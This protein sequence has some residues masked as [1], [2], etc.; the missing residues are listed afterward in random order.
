MQFSEDHQLI[1]DVVNN[2]QPVKHKRLTFITGKL[3]EEYKANKKADETIFKIR[4]SADW[5]LGHIV[6]DDIDIE[7]IDFDQVRGFI[8]QDLNAGVSGSTIN[9]HLYGLKQIWDRAK[10]SKPVSGENPFSKHRVAKDSQSYDIYEWHEIKTMY[11]AAEDDLKIL[12]HTAATTGARINEL[13]TAE[14][15][16]LKTSIQERPCCMFKFKGKGKTEQSTRA[17]PLHPTLQ[18]PDGFTF[19][20]SDRTVTRRFRELKEKTLDHP[21]NITT[22]KPRKLSFHSFRSTVVTELIEKHHI[23]EKVV[24]IRNRTPCGLG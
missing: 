10:S 15:M 7:V 2:R 23:N 21:I 14:V 16:I 19:K 4:R 1:L 5:F 13:L 6:Q 20:M 22:G 9:G 17:V 11:D 3:L 8:T 12:I 18:L 24:R